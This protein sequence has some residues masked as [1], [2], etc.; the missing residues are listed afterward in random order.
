MAGPVRPGGGRSIEGGPGSTLGGRGKPS[1]V[2]CTTGGVGKSD[3][4]SRT[5]SGCCGISE[6]ASGTAKNSSSK[7]EVIP[8]TCEKELRSL[9]VSELARAIAALMLKEEI[10]LK[11]LRS[12]IDATDFFDSIGMS[13]LTFLLMAAMRFSSRSSRCDKVS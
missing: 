1:A 5:G 7:S 6:T 4:G 10:V 2:V 11:S 8:V 12:L 9:L 13:A 3:T